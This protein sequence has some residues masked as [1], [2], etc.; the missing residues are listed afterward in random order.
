MSYWWVNLGSTYKYEVRGFMWSPQQGAR[1]RIQSYENMLLIKPGDV[2]FAFSDSQ[3]KAIGIATSTAQSSPK[4]DFGSAGSHWANEGWLV[5]VLF[6]ELTTPIR[7]RDYIKALEGYLPERHSPLRPDGNANQAY[8]FEVPKDMA[9]RVAGLIGEE[10]NH[11]TS[12]KIVFAQ[13]EITDD[14]IES[15]LKM[16]IGISETEKLQLVKSRRGQGLFKVNVQLVESKCR[17]TGVTQPN[18]LIASHIK[19]WSKSNDEEKLDGF[20]GLLLAPHVDRLFDRGLMSFKQN[21]ELLISPRLDL[22]VLNKW[23]ISEYL[24]VGNFRA[25]QENYLE[26]HRDEVFKSA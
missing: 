11:I 6:T 4:P 22:D 2:I 19:P 21:G 13:D 9:L 18:L 23:H 10:F 8:L 14:P 24:A 26:Y 1:G 20:N 25:E 7:I 17:V 12:L 15:E 3:I 5:E 16:R